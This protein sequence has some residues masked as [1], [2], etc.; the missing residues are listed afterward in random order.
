MN[1]SIDQMRISMMI[2]LLS[3]LE[4]PDWPQGP[5]QLELFN[6]DY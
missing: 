6:G 4:D 1:R 5:E 2:V 3:V